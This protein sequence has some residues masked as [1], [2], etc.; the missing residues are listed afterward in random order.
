MTESAAAAAEAP[1]PETEPTPHA[2][3]QRD[4]HLFL[5][6]VLAEIPFEGWTRAALTR[7]ADRLGWDAVKVEILFPEGVIDVIA[8]WSAAAD[9]AMLAAMEGLDPASMKVRAR[10]HTAIKL[11]LDAAAPHR[12]AL[13]RALSVLAWPTH[14]ALSAKLLHRTVD[15]IWY[16]AG[17]RSTDF[18]WYTKRGL[19]APVY[20]ATVLYWLQDSSTD[21]A[22]TWEFLS[23]R[24]EGVLRIGKAIAPVKGLAER[25]TKGF[26]GLFGRFSARPRPDAA[27][28]PEA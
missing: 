18:N 5:E 21:H 14:A 17:D 12:D 1:Q 11:R 6:A 9:E 22:A 28:Q 26:E 27:P 23:R 2:A 10:I 24:L 7:A 3:D 16:A 20:G 8:F 19:L 4:R 25:C 13:G 15:T